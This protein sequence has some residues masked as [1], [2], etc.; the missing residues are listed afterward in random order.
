MIENF[1][2]RSLVGDLPPD[3]EAARLIGLYDAPLR[4][5]PDDAARQVDLPDRLTGNFRDAAPRIELARG[6]LAAE[7]KRR[8]GRFAFGAVGRDD[9]AFHHADDASL[10]AEGAALLVGDDP[11]APQVDP[12]PAADANPARAAADRGISGDQVAFN[13]DRAVRGGV[14]TLAGLVVVEVSH[15]VDPA[16]VVAGGVADDPVVIDRRGGIP[17]HPDAARVVVDRRRTHDDHVEGDLRRALVRAGD[18]PA[19]RAAR[20]D[21][22]VKHGVVLHAGDVVAEDVA[23]DLAVDLAARGDAGAVADLG[24]VFADQ[25]VADRRAR[26]PK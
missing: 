17:L 25:I 10:R 5:D 8:R 20:A 14:E 19:G 16:A 15:D 12:A 21:L 1:N 9:V 4:A 22:A 3:D 24:A 7:T 13:A 2:L 26:A 23:E 11:V 6:D 18:R